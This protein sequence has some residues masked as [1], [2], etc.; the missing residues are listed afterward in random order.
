MNP[1]RT[2][3]LDAVIGG[4]NFSGIL[5]AQTG[6]PYSPGVGTGNCN[7]GYS[8][9][10]RPDALEPFFLGGTGRDTPRFKRDAFDYPGVAADD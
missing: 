7:I 4:L 3:V 6:L 2:R 10:C 5:S 1:S 9:A 8:N